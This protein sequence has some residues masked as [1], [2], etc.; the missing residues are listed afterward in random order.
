MW[1]ANGGAIGAKVT[2]LVT[3]NT[4]F[5]GYHLL[6]FAAPAGTRLAATTKYFVV[7]YRVGPEG[8]MWVTST[9]D[10]GDDAGA[11]AG[12]SIDDDGLIRAI[13]TPVDSGSFWGGF[14]GGQALRI[15]VNGD[16]ARRTGVGIVFTDSID[17]SHIPTGEVT[18]AKTYLSNV[19][20][21][22][23]YSVGAQRYVFGASGREGPFLLNVTDPTNI[24]YTDPAFNA[25][26][27]L[28]DVAV[29]TASD[30]TAQ[31]I[32]VW[33]A[34]DAMQRYTI[35]GS[36][37]LATGNHVID[38]TAMDGAS[39]VA[40]Y[41]IGAKDYAVVTGRN[42]DSVRVVDISTPTTFALK[43]SL[44]DTA[45]LALDRPNRVEV[46]TIGAKHYAA[47]ASD[48]GLQI[49]DVT[50]PD[51]IAASGDLTI[52]DGIFNKL[53]SVALY[54]VG[55]SHYAVVGS[56]DDNGGV[57]AGDD[58]IRG[59]Q[60]INVTD[61]ANPSVV[62]R[63]SPAVGLVL[64]RTGDVA[65][66]RVG[67]R[68]FAVV[69]ATAPTVNGA[70]QTGLSDERKRQTDG[71]SVIDVTDPASPEPLVSASHSLGGL[72]LLGA[73]SVSSF[74][75]DGRYYG[76]VGN[77][78]EV[79]AERSHGV[80][81]FE[82]V[83]LT[84]D[85]GS[86]QMVDAGS[87]VTLD[88][89]GSSVTNSG[90]LTYGWV[91]VSGPDV[92]LSPVSGSP[93]QATFTTPTTES[94]LVFELVVTHGRPSQPGRSAAVD[95]MTV[96]VLAPTALTLTT[97]AVNDSVGEGAGSVSVT[98]TLDRPALSGG[99]AVT[100]TASGSA[101]AGADFVLPGAF[102][103]PAG[104]TSA[105]A[106][107]RIV[108]DDSPESSETVVL[109]ASAAGLS[110][111]PVTLTVTDDDIPGVTL[112]ALSVSAFEGFTA[113]YTVRLNTQPTA[114]VT[115]TPTSG[116][117][118]A[119]TVSDALT[120]TPANW[121]SSQQVTVTGVAE[122]TSA[123][124]HTVT[125]TDSDYSAVT[126]GSVTA[127]VLVPQTKYSITPALTI[128]EF[129]TA[130]A[131][132]V[133]LGQAAPAGGI[134]FAVAYDYSGGTATRGDLRA[135]PATV[136]VKEGDTTAQLRLVTRHDE[137]VED[138]ETFTVTITADATAQ[139]AGW[140]PISGQ[141]TATVTI[142]DD[143][144]AEASVGFGSAVEPQRGAIAASRNSRSR[145][146]VTLSRPP[147]TPVTV[148]VEVDPSSTATEYVDDNN[149]GDFRIVDKTVTFTPGGSRGTSQTLW[150]DITNSAETANE[151]IVLRIADHSG[152]GLGRHYTRYEPNRT[153]TITLWPRT[154][155][156][157]TRDPVDPVGPVDPGPGPVGPIG[158]GGPGGGSDDDGD[159]RDTSRLAGEDRYA[160]S[161]RIAEQVAE[162]NDG[163][164]ATIVLAGGHSWT[165]AL[166]AA[167]LAGALDAALLLT[168]QQ[169]LPADTITWLKEIGVTEVIAVGDSTHITDEALD[170]LRTALNNN[171]GDGAQVR[172]ER[173]AEVSPYAMSAA[174]ARRIGQPDTLGPLLGRTVIIASGQRFPDALAAGPLAAAGPHPV[175]YADTGELH[176]D[177]AAYLAAHADHVIIMGGTAAVSDAVEQQIRDIKQANRPARPMAVTRHAGT[178][179]YHT[180]ALFARWLTGPVLEG[181][182]CFTADTAGLAT[183][184]NPADAA[185]SGPLLA[186]RCAPL[187]LTEPDQMPQHT[188]SFLRSTTELIVF[189]GTKAI[190]NAALRDWTQ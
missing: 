115:V 24:V 152:G 103:I 71:F 136:T 36:G 4:A 97:S 134:T 187:L 185:A 127:T 5:S 60:I 65:I 147:A 138:D 123:I 15:V 1:S 160:T 129:E 74:A 64:D 31:M 85:A 43:D 17:D 16:E 75:K 22:E 59:I 112:S 26:T 102:T 12:W 151:T 153:Y 69:P 21:V 76:V 140:T 145:V 79:S 32:G 186:H 33:E 50:D 14:S 86:D 105:T 161:L 53:H 67:D 121:K 146:S 11:P 48:E 150:V 106:N 46:Y 104:K 47:V 143:D 165:D 124:S 178:D 81:L 107:V 18:K 3:P 35:N 184:L 149:P 170:A 137:V 70:R 82:M 116:T 130:R 27:G 181:R 34:S 176:P 174:V 183:G 163:T 54:S 57:L 92:V 100:L 39:G 142:T 173:I 89:S 80:Q 10:S 162:A 45:M 62:S 63:L 90:N 179:R 122:G 144:T 141:N 101:T 99:V 190:N 118:A 156:S 132:T 155:R 125:T 84:A 56:L 25:A 20:A 95:K 108:D 9:S 88:G 72:N 114:N 91:Q 164:L 66:H 96:S 157:T 159:D 40:V 131:L 68:V 2:D 19:V 38:A 177:V 126:V 8:N 55:S 51:D 110:V 109:S 120:F 167:P 117:T 23:A 61:P 78:E 166:T 73:R 77:W 94:D 119:A 29:Y 37:Q 111:T 13:D 169:G 139:A 87:T 113:S 49:V 180:A 188:R 171:N 28:S 30:N 98:A 128:P 175:L 93:H 148:E 182:V 41:E 189:G 154:Q 83:F 52:S 7:I 172:V 158:G 58:V 42:S 133:T 168:P 44:A 6:R 135:A